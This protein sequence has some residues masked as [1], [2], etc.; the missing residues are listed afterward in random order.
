MVQRFLPALAILVALAGCKTSDTIPGLGE[1]GTYDVARVSLALPVTGARPMAVAVIDER[2]YV[3]DGS[4]STTF[5]GTDRG[6]WRQEINVKTASGSGLA[7]DLTDV[8]AGALV[9]GGA[10][11]TPLSLDDD[12]DEAEALAAFQ[13]QGAERLLLVRVQDWNS[14][15]YTRVILQ[16]RFEATVRGRDGAVLGGN[17]VSGT[18]PVGSTGASANTEQTIQR[19]LSTHL[20]NV[21]GDP[22][23]TGALR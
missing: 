7:E 3:L 6:K 2:P 5:L 16:W 4:E 10:E 23:I 22:R 15:A 19:E 11:A 8:I 14:N 13:A 17:T 21:L 9:R 20:S 1:S 18:A 12:A